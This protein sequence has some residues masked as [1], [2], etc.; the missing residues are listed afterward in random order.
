M[1]AH[2][3]PGHVVVARVLGVRILGITPRDEGGAITRTAA[4]RLA[5]LQANAKV[6]LAGPFATLAQGQEP[7]GPGGA[8]RGRGGLGGQQ[9]TRTIV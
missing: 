8:A 2:H 5:V 7:G 1:I 6:A 4:M 3:E 9:A